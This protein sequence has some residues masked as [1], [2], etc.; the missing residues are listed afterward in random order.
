[1]G[2]KFHNPDTKSFFP[3]HQ[4]TLKTIFQARDEVL[5]L[6]VRF[7]FLT[8]QCNLNKSLKTMAFVITLTKVSASQ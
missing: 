4:S 7:P 8:N 3:S 1:M 5:C 6:I 2:K